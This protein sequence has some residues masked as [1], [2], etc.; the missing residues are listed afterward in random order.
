M[1][2]VACYTFNPFMPNFPTLSIEPV[3]FH[4]KACYIVF[5]NFIQRGSYMVWGI[6]MEVCPRLEFDNIMFI[7]C[8]GYDL[9]NEVL[10]Q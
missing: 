8:L 4:F 5:F 1:H 3:H 9:F 10:T 7:N 6:N 2:T